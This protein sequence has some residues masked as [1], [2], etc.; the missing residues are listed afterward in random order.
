L[1]QLNE[2]AIGIAEKVLAVKDWEKWKSLDDS[3]PQMLKISSHGQWRGLQDSV[4]LA[5]SLFR[6]VASMGNI[7]VRAGLATYGREH[8]LGFNLPIFRYNVAAKIFNFYQTDDLPGEVLRQPL[9]HFE[10]AAGEVARGMDSGQEA[11]I[12]SGKKFMLDA[13][14]GQGLCHYYLAKYL[15]SRTMPTRSE[16]VAA[17]MD[18]LPGQSKAQLDSARLAYESISRNLLY[19]DYFDSIRSEMPVNLQTLLEAEE[20]VAKSDNNHSEEDIKREIVGYWILAQENILFQL[21]KNGTAISI[22]YNKN[23]VDT[24]NVGTWLVAD[25]NLQLSEDGDTEVYKILLINNQQLILKD[26]KRGE[27]LKLRRI[28]PTDRDRDGVLDAVDNCPGE[29]GPAKNAGCP[30]NQ[31]PNLAPAVF[32][33]IDSISLKPIAGALI[34]IIQSGFSTIETDITGKAIFMNLP[35]GKID[36]IV[37][38]ENYF[39]KTVSLNISSDDKSNMFSIPINNINKNGGDDFFLTGEVTDKLGRMIQNAWVEVKIADLIKTVVTDKSGNFTVEIPSGSRYNATSMQV[40]IRERDCKKTETID[41]PRQKVLY[42]DFVLDCI[43]NDPTLIAS[44]GFEKSQ[45][46]NKT[47]KSVRVVID[48]PEQLG[49]MVNI[50][51]TLENIDLK[52]PFIDVSMSGNSAELISLDGNTFESSSIL[53][54]NSKSDANFKARLISGVPVKGTLKFNVGKSRVE[55]ISLLKMP[56]QGYGVIEFRGIPVK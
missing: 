28:Q 52:E 44:P 21:R 25:K 53:L 43:S 19:P 15:A 47:L 9:R 1:I 45:V 16:R 22:E 37:A 4:R 14:H 10:W 48:Y 35:L 23:S 33:I 7:S 12:N 13:R 46:A 3:L 31:N 17:A 36:C 20:A 29:S 49:N 11:S 18:S 41:I 56:L 39:S 8:R 24:S 51:F 40:N 30:R 5:D 50:P 27:V 32:I 42:K 34:T 2:R 54:A 38:K 55:T 26:E 6:Q